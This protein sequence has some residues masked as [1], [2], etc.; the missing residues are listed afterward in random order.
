[1]NRACLVTF[2]IGSLT[3]S[4]GMSGGTCNVDVGDVDLDVNQLGGDGGEPSPGG[5]PAPGGGV[6]TSLAR[7]FGHAMT[8]DASRQEIVLFGGGTGGAFAGDETWAWDGSEWSQKSPDNKPSPRSFHAMAF[9]S[10]RNVVVLFGGRDPGESF[11]DTW[12]WDGADWTRRT[13]AAVPP[14]LS[15]GQCAMAYDAARQVSVLCAGGTWEWDGANWIERTSSC[16]DEVMAYDAARQE[17]VAFGRQTWT[18]DGADWTERTPTTSPPERFRGVRVG[19]RHAMAY[20]S[21]R[22]VVVLF[23]GNDGAYL[24]DTW[25]WDGSNWSQQVRTDHPF[26]RIGHAMA[27]DSL[28]SVVVLFG[29]AHTGAD[30][31]ETSNETWLWDGTT[32]HQRTP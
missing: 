18:W 16:P 17:V 26:K 20:D 11:N 6:Q 12:E 29:G 30:G 9:D 13:P 22:N 19:S 15:S 14:R 23:G 3:F 1:M 7:R 32:W 28:S 10:A 21:T 4:L 25:E 31:P 2:L 8:Y 24:D 5:D 27:Y